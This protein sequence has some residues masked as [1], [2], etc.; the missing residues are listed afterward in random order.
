MKQEYRYTSFC[1]CAVEVPL[2]YM[3]PLCFL[4][5]NERVKYLL[6]ISFVFNYVSQSI[7]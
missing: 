1:E 2:L 4:V 6:D 3:C 7:K 5:K